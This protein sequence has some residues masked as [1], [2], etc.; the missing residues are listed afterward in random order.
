MIEEVLG[1]FP[2][3]SNRPL[4]RLTPP[5]ALPAPSHEQVPAKPEQIQATDVVFAQDS[6]AAAVAG[7]LGL[8]GSTM[9]LTDLAKDHFQVSDDPDD[10]PNLN[11]LDPPESEE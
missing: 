2:M 7:L 11:Q 9:L 8:W 1:A 6:N 5:V 3:I 10:R 4:E